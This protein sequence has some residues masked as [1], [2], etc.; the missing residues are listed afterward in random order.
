MQ[1]AQVAWEQIEQTHG[2]APLVLTCEHASNHLPSPW[3]WSPADEWCISTHWA[4]DIGAA[5][6]TRELATSLGAPAVLSRFS[7]LLV[8]PNRAPSQSGLFR[9]QAE[10]RVLALNE[11]LPADEQ[12]RRLEV[13]YRPYHAAIDGVLA[14]GPW[15]GLVSVH[16]FTPVYEQQTRT[17]EVG[18]LFNDC[19]AQAETL[20]H[21]LQGHYQTA[22][23]QPYTGKG[24]KFA[25]SPY[26]H[27]RRAGLPWLELEVRQD[28]SGDTARRRQLVPV[29]TDGLLAAFGLST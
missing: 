22:L 9:R 24:G 16:T 21:R 17:V 25:F 14:G 2:G 15:R 13:C 26:D 28:I 3:R 5:E 12:Q 7:R 27:A 8:D 6:L 29:L 10:G 23:N 19:Q 11:D 1:A 4:F 18:V 20:A